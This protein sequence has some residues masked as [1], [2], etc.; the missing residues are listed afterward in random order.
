LIMANGKPSHF[1]RI[2]SVI[3]ISSVEHSSS[4]QNIL[5]KNNLLES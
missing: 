5:L 1:F 2:S 3:P 4:K